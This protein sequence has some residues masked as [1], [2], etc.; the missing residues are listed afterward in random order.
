MVRNVVIT[1]RSIYYQDVE[2]FGSQRAVD[3]VGWSFYWKS[4]ILQLIIYSWKIIEDI[5]YQYSV[6][7]HNLNIVGAAD[8]FVCQNVFQI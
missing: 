3:Q 2:L 8:N 5:A 4:W 1:K 7:R 6:P